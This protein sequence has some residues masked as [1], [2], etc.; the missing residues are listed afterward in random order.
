[1][2]GAAIESDSDPD[3]GQG[4]AR[5]VERMLTGD[6]A[7]MAE[8]A[9]GYFPGLYRFAAA[10]LGG[11]RELTRDVVQTTACKALAKL[12]SYRGE[13]PLAAWLRACCR[14]EIRMYFRWRKGLPRV[15]ELDDPRDLRELEDLEGGA[16]A[17]RQLRQ[18]GDHPERALARKE[19]ARLVHATLDLLP[20]AYARAL[21]WKYVERLPVVEI[22]ARLKLGAKAAESLLT[23]ARRA[24]RVS[25]ERQGHTGRA[26][27]AVHERGLEP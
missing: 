25:Y 3:L 26:G 13:A 17:A 1:M 7:A 22:A 11:D 14:N 19:E 16:G 9:D 12:A 24:F 27:A 20:P 2:S 21:E 23:R 4:E 6:E 5:L 15:V 10:L 18:P 8:F